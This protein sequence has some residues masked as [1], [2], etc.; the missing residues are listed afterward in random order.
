MNNL[1]FLFCLNLLGENLR[2]GLLGGFA[3]SLNLNNYIVG[4][5]ILVQVFVQTS[6]LYYFV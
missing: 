5:T 4:W 1:N 2:V 3:K 6:I